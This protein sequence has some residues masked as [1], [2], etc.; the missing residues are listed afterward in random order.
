MLI[1]GVLPPGLTQLTATYS[2]CMPYPADVLE[3]QRRETTSRGYRISY[4]VAG[5][6]EPV[7]LVSGMGQSAVHWV[8]DGYVEALAETRRVIVPD[9]LGHGESDKPHDPA[10][11]T[12]P[13]VALDVLAALDAEGVHDPV[14]LW[15]YSRGM[16]LAFI[17]ALEAPGR[18]AR[19]VGGAT[20]LDVPTELV[21]AFFQPLAAPMQ[22]GD[23]PGYWALFGPAM[24]DAAQRRRFEE[25]VDTDAAA[26][27]IL[28]SAQ[29]PY[30][31]DLSR[32]RAPSL[33]YVGER[34]MFAGLMAEDARK[35]G[36]RLVVLS[37]LDHGQAY[38]QREHVYAD[39]TAFLDER[40]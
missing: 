35:L 31:F 1:G 12:E 5:A 10:A 27:W 25:T 20:A 14:G 8:E 4:L 28:G 11:Y 38:L 13:E 30:E 22:A 23:W 3:V 29:R 26:A 40:G 34:D 19:I 15:G 9:V 16:R 33:L 6:G 24:A 39:A 17:L 18:V 36:S 2:R 32:V 21:S 7:V 37:G